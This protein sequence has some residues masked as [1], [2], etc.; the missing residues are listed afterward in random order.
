MYARLFH[1]EVEVEG[2]GD[3]LSTHTACA[4]APFLGQKPPSPRPR[5][6]AGVPISLS[7]QPHASQALPTMLKFSDPLAS[8]GHFLSQ[9]GA[10][11]L[12]S[13]RLPM[14]SH[15]PSPPLLHHA[16]NDQYPPLL[17]D[18]F[19]DA[20]YQAP[21]RRTPWAKAKAIPS[22]IY[23]ASVA[24]FGRRR[25]PVLLCL[26]GFALLFATFVVHRRFMGGRRRPH[27]PFP[28]PDGPVFAE[29]EVRKIW[30]WEILAG[31]YPSTRPS[32]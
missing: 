20:F 7:P 22:N 15:S 18:S 28:S 24:R 19:D 13:S 26:C 25:G 2:G 6:K 1:V 21:R 5:T 31:H 14:P 3:A 11:R 4:A 17:H 27:L 8:G 16:R 10:P 30:E 32:E 29:A 23:R 12:R 9:N